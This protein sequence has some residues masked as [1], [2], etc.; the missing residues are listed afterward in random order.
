M[1][2]DFLTDN[3]NF[4]KGLENTPDIPLECSGELRSSVKMLEDFLYL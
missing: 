2:P 1:L 4:S 3:F